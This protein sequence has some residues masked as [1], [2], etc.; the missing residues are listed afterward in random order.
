MAIKSMKQGQMSKNAFLKEAEIMREFRHE[1]LVAIY[2]VCTKTNPI[3][4]IQEYMCYGS[5]LDFLR[6]SKVYFSPN[7]LI[8]FS[9][10]IAQ[11][12]K[13][14]ESRKLVHSDLA[15]R[16]VLV[17]QNKVV[18]ISDFGLARILNGESNENQGLKLAVRWTAPE[19]FNKRI[20]YSTKSDV[21]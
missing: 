10:Q 15:A 5:L 18:K 20:V 2:A 7:D 12:M 6:R 13:F 19:V 17:G 11:G 3:W 14:L 1:K 21:W 9:T 16:N 4:I 8:Y